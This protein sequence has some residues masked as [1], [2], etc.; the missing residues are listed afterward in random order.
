MLNE[1]TLLK[2]RLRKKISQKR[3][4]LLKKKIIKNSAIIKK[5]LFETNE[6]K[7]AQNIMFYVSFKSEV[8]TYDMIRESLQKGKRIFVPITKLK[9]KKLIISEIKDFDKELELSTYGILEPK[10][11]FQKIYN[12]NLLNLI[13]VPGVAFDLKGNRIGYGGGYYDKFLRSISPKVYKIG[14]C[15][16]CQIVKNIPVSLY[17]EK[18]TI[19]ITEKGVRVVK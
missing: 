4:I 17:D 10:E 16:E 9:E 12:L 15:F 11:E 5:I 2:K 13:V 7:L 1:I 8:V 6:F 19:L 14:L 18:V 3:D